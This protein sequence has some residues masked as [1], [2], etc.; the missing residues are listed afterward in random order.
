MK[1]KRRRGRFARW[2]LAAGLAGGSLFGGPG[3]IGVLQRELEVLTRPE[4]SA[5]FFYDSIL[6]NHPFGRWLIRYWNPE[7]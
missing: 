6:F 7:P 5:T 3:C 4:V 1:A 2:A